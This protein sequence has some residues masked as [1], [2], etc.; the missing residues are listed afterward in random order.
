MCV[1]VCELQ[2]WRAVWICIKL[3]K[4]SSRSLT[5]GPT[6]MAALP[7]LQSQGVV[8]SQGQRLSGVP[9]KR[10]NDGPLPPRH[11]LAVAWLGGR[12]LIRCSFFISLQGER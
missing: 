8:T 4:G 6:A 1:C 12:E 11:G 10:V 2:W 7:A 9:S 5:G 3:E